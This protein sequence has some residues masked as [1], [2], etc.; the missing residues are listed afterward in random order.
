[1][2]PATIFSMLFFPLSIYFRNRFLM[3]GI[4]L[5]VST[6]GFLLIVI[7]SIPNFIAILA[8]QLIMFLHVYPHQLVK[9]FNEMAHEEKGEYLLN[10][11]RV[12]FVA[13]ILHSFAFVMLKMKYDRY[14][15]GI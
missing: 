6:P 5:A 10:E 3:V 2:L 14:S 9:V 7:K 8:Y 4:I 12:C 13:L 15:T 11:V 1:M